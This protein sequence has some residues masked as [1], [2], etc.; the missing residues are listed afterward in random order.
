MYIYNRVSLNKR[1]ITKQCNIFKNRYIFTWQNSDIL[2]KASVSRSLEVTDR[3]GSMLDH[4]YNYIVQE[5]RHL[6]DLAQ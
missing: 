6:R 1:F 4:L 2:T 3:A 5:A